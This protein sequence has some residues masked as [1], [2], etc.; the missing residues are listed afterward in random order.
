MSLFPFLAVLVCTMGVLIIL[1]VLVTKL[2]DDQAHNQREEKAEEVAKKIDQVELD[3]ETEKMRVEVIRGLRPKLKKKLETE[4]AQRS[5]VENEI[6]D[7][8][9]KIEDQRQRLTALASSNPDK[10]KDPDIEKAQREIQKLSEQI[11]SA[12]EKLTASQQQ[13]SSESVVYSVVPHQGTGGSNRRPIYVE[14][15][16]RGITFQPYGITL[17]K[18]DFVRPVLPGNPFDSALLAIREYWLKLGLVDSNTQPYPLMIVR[19]DGADAYGLVRQ[20]M[21]NWEDQFGYEL[22]EQETKLDFGKADSELEKRIRESIQEAKRFQRALVAKAVRNQ[23]IARAKGGGSRIPQGGM[24]ASPSGGF[25]MADG[26][27]FSS[28]T[29]KSKTQESNLPFESIDSKVAQQTGDR[30]KG[31]FDANRDSKSAAKHSGGSGNKGKTSGASSMASLAQ[32][33]GKDWA[34]PTRTQG[35]TAYK[36][37][38]RIICDGNQIT[39]RPSASYQRMSIPIEKDT[40][41]TVDQLVDRVWKIIDSWDIAGTGGYWKPELVFEVGEDGNPAYEEIAK[42]LKGSG[43][44]TTRIKSP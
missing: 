38:I 21:R 11:E 28:Q 2:A 20:A 12:K 4:K 31:Q 39:I 44:D 36:R 23:Q 29:W 10:A 30:N 26:Q 3:L 8:R 40:V 14:C 1:L 19:P 34:L 22:I 41:K 15:D 25:V 16:Q 6:I 9:K 33:R 32:K 37:P 18:S 7:L 42:L 5:F 13:S 35:A 17:K 24:R 27:R 43:L